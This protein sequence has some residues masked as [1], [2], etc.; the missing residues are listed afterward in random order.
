MREHR[1]RTWIVSAR[2]PANPSAHPTWATA[3]EAVWCRTVATILELFG[4]EGQVC[5]ADNRSPHF[6]QKFK[7]DY[8]PTQELC[9]L[10]GPSRCVCKSKNLVPA[11][12]LRRCDSQ[13]S[14]D[15]S[16]KQLPTY[17]RW[18]N[19][20]RQRTAR[21]SG[22]L[23]ARVD[24]M[25]CLNNHQ[26]P[27]SHTIG[28]FVLAHDG[29]YETG[30]SS[31]LHSPCFRRTRSG[32]GLHCAREPCLDCSNTLHIPC[33]RNTCIDSWICLLLCPRL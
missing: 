14:Q 26:N 8:I 18:I 17:T 22:I 5:P 20:S 11:P 30:C 4:N 6:V 28:T 33:F 3:E 15:R 23:N 31:T 21:L 29:A 2:G 32:P 16:S 13:D 24:E 19:E 12:T 27:C 1:A 9:C 25:G 10:V 7:I